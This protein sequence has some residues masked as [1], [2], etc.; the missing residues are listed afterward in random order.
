MAAQVDYSARFLTPAYLERDRSTYLSLGVY[1]AGALAAPS[2][3]EIQ[4]YDASNTA[5]VA[6]DT[7]V[8]IRSSVA[9]YTLESSVVSSKSLGAGWR[10][11]WSLT[12]P[13]GYVHVLRQDAAL[14]RVRLA[15]VITDADLLARHTDLTNL[16]PANQSSYQGYIDEA[17]RD[18]LGRLEAAGRRPYLVISPE[19]LRPVH[20]FTTL[21][22]IFR[23]FAGSGDPTNK[24]TMLA[25]H[26]SKEGERGWA[27]LSLVYDETDSGTGSARRRQGMTSMWLT[28]RGGP[29]W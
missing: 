26:Y 21:E 13:D 22:L 12:M 15:P 28:S 3:G 18:V 6:D 2:V 5:L 1:T 23:D 4:I 20:L 17:W 19:A 8:R 27:H 14:V 25:E 9:N 29:S 24:W 10:V 11:E 7:A 16:R